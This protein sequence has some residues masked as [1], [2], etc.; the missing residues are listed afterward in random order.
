[1]PNTLIPVDAMYSRVTGWND[2]RLT[3]EPTWTSVNTSHGA[4]SGFDRFATKYIFRRLR[5]SSDPITQQMA[6]WR[7]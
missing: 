7:P 6:R 1:M 5:P 3:H 2:P 4:T